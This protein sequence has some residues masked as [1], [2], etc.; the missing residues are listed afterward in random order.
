PGQPRRRRGTE[1][2][3]RTSPPQTT[4]RGMDTERLA[5]WFRE[6]AAIESADLPR[7]RA[8]SAGIAEHDEMLELLATAAPGQWR[9]VLLFAA[10]HDLVLRTPD[11]A[12]ARLYP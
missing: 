11:A 10:F 12:Y 1:E 8:L 7:Y 4:F 6:F 3:R 9:P 2:G 5:G